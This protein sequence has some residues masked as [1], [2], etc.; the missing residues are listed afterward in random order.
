MELLEG[1]DKIS[2]DGTDGRLS[3][4]SPT[5][6]IM[7]EKVQLLATTV[8]QEFEKMISDYDANVVKSLM[9]IVVDILESLEESYTR[10]EEVEVQLEMVSED[11][12]QLE[13]EYQKEKKL[14]M[15]EAKRNF[16]L[17]D[18]FEAQQEES[19]TRLNNL[20]SALKTYE[21]KKN[22]VESRVQGLEEDLISQIKGENNKKSI[23]DNTQKEI[24][25]LVNT[26]NVLSRVRDDLI[27][28]IDK[29]MVEK[30]DLEEEIRSLQ[31]G[32]SALQRQLNALENNFPNQPTEINSSVKK[33]DNSLQS[34]TDQN[35]FLETEV[36]EIRERVHALENSMNDK[37]KMMNRR[38][39][40]RLSRKFDAEDSFKDAEGNI[41]TWDEIERALL[42][43]NRSNVKYVDLQDAI[44]WTATMNAKKMNAMNEKAS[45]RSIKRSKSRQGNVTF[46]QGDA[47]PKESNNAIRRFFAK[48][49]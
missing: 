6:M 26:K 20:N 44:R 38:L 3:S 18:S 8:Y 35:K 27:G 30:D 19:T 4:P 49:I 47:E 9:P 12:E 32:K 37:S 40:R 36:D 39:S 25:H 13:S 29:L 28:N 42:E 48:F 10:T 14:R 45:R 5:K 15:A 31:D 21:T 11:L 33:K 17:E 22:D 7:N 43:P 2:V 23:K 34:A 46:E 16:E 41:F 24:N 1:K